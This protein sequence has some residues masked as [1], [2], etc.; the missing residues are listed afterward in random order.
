[1]QT[2]SELSETQPTIARVLQNSVRRGRLAHAYLFEGGRGTGRRAAALLL[3]R[4]FLCEKTVDAEPCLVCRECRRAESGN[5]PDVHR[6]Q[7]DGQTIKVDQIRALKKEFSMR[8]ME[9]AKKVYIIEE[10]E[11][12]SAAAANSLLKFLEEPEGEALAVLI[13]ASAGQILPT[14]LSRAQVMSFSPLPPDR[15]T[16]ALVERGFREKEARTAASLTSDLEEAERM[17]DEEWISQG[18]EKVVQLMNDLISRP[19][20]AYITVHETIM[21]FFTDRQQIQTALDLM[22]IWYRDVLRMQVGQSDAVVYIDQEDTLTKQAFQLSQQKLG[23]NLQA[24]M[25]AKRRAGAN[26]PPQLLVEQ[27]LLRLQEGS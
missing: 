7:P 16:K 5:H 18:R 24:V 23:K 15:V 11:T 19:Q 4:A 26:V 27:L 22:M 9:S 14:I 3:A 20:D 13:T 21:P 17:F 10:T 2:W 8:G 12:M 1:M 6:I 25:D